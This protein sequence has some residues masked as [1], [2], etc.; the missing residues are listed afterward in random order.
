MSDEKTKRI[1]EIFE[2]V[3]TEE[4]NEKKKLWN[5]KWTS[6]DDTTNAMW[7]CDVMQIVLI[8]THIF[9]IFIVRQNRTRWWC[10]ALKSS[11]NGR[12]VQIIMHNVRQT[13]KYDEN[14]YE[15]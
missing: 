14:L 11:I 7:I 1:E 4:K 10:D 9:I 12:K 13:M 8:F 2:K 5:F 15:W 3:I 6:L